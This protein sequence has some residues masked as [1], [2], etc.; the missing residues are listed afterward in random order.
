MLLPDSLFE[1]FG[2]Y[3]EPG[4]IIFCEYEKGHEVY[5]IQEGRVKI[6]KTVGVSQK[7]LDIL[8]SGDFFGEMAILEEEPRSAT[9][10]AID[11]VKTLHF[12]R[13]NFD[14]L[15]TGNPHLALR[16]LTTF[17][18]R[19]F[20][21]RRRL[22]IL[23]HKDIDAKVSD[24]L[25]MLAEKDP[26]FERG[27]VLKLNVTV[28]DVASW[29]GQHPEEVQATLLNFKKK[30]KIDIFTDSLTIRNVSDYKRFAQNLRKK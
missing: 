26:A 3:F 14:S 23:Q 1:K 28:N 22:E 5:F 21:A 8:S 12:N 10:V 13:K 15:M 18:T 25:L 20:D 19:I 24:V 6:T 30:G 17:A 16:L 4:Q 9:A 2:I 29:C 27:D 11:R 7:T